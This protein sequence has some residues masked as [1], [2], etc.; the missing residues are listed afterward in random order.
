MVRIDDY[1]S[2][3]QTTEIVDLLR[4]YQDVFAHDYK[5]IKGTVEEMG[6]IKIDLISGVKPTK[7]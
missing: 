3:K 5:Y 6:G 1:W 4:E 2:N 7:K